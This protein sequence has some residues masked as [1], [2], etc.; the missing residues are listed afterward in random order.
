MSADPTDDG[1]DAPLTLQGM[2]GGRRRKR[3]PD[4]TVLV[5][6]VLGVL[7]AGAGYMALKKGAHALPAGAVAKGVPSISQ[8]ERCLRNGNIPCAEASYIAYLKQY[9][10]DARANAMLAI[11]L[12]GDG[13]HKEALPYYRKAD[14]LGID[15]YDFYANQA[16]SLEATG[17][18]DGAIKANYRALDIVPSLVDVRGSLADL[19]V[20]KGRADEA[21]NL[22]ESFDRSLEDQGHTPY[23][24]AKAARIR[25]GRGGAAAQQAAADAAV[26]AA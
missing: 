16:R 8:A 14:A 26:T 6:S 18:V 17:D 13:R 21:I 12:T 2:S 19:L 25:A 20:R 4:V 9:P 11:V 15:T 24:T 1:A 5:I 22:L 7:G 23:F 10:E 3:G